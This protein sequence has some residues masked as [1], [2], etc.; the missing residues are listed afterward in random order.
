MCMKKGDKSNVKMRSCMTKKKKCYKGLE[1]DPRIAS[2][3]KAE[4][5]GNL[6]NFRLLNSNTVSDIS[7]S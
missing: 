6:S 5:V 4:T 1:V 2:V 3:R 7:Y